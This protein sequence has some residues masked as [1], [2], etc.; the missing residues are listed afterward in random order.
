MTLADL[1]SYR[2]RQNL[3]NGEHNRDGTHNDHS[4]DCGVQG[5]TTDA[6]VLMHR[7]RRARAMVAAL[8]L[9]R[10]VPMLRAGDEFGAT[11]LGNNNAYCHDSP[12]TCRH[13]PMPHSSRP[14]GCWPMPTCGR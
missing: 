4:D 14:P 11:Q 7:S 5:P 8:M 13:R 9:S 1:V 2:H 12:L 6:S 3:A 10:G